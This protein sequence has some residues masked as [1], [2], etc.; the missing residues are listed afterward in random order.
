[1]LYV[2]YYDPAYVWDL[3][4][5]GYYVHADHAG[6]GFGSSPVSTLE[7]FWKGL[8]WGGRGWV[9]HWNSCSVFNVVLLQP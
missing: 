7:G 9:W 3:Y 8:G 2:P 6:Y 5:V 4:G 1:M